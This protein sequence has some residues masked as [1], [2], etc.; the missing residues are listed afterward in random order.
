MAAGDLRTT[1][2]RVRRK[3]ARKPTVSADD[4][5]IAGDGNKAHARGLCSSCYQAA[6]ARVN[7]G[8]AT[9]E[10]LEAAGLAKP[11]G[12]IAGRSAFA[13]KFARLKKNGK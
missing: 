1:P 3:K 8:D 4:Q 2:G 5:C 13:Q 12:G 6:R 9:W 11:S 10:K 7:S